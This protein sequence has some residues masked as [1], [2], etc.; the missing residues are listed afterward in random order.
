MRCV[1]NVED[2]CTFP[3]GS[4]A[5]ER[6]SPEEAENSGAPRYRKLISAFSIVRRRSSIS[7]LPVRYRS[8]P[9]PSPWFGNS[10]KAADTE[11]MDSVIE[12][13]RAKYIG[14]MG[15]N[16]PTVRDRSTEPPMP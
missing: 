16:H 5:G 11:R 13:T 12:F 4:E 14:Y 15:V 6:R 9:Y 1:R 8:A 2:A 7:A 3:Q 10:F